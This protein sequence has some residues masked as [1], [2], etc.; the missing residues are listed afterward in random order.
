MDG[1]CSNWANS[2]VVF[3][4]CNNDRNQ[5]TTTSVIMGNACCS[6][7]ERPSKSNLI[8][9]PTSKS[10]KKHRYE[11]V[12][13]DYESEDDVWFDAL[14]YHEDEEQPGFEDEKQN[15]GEQSFPVTAQELITLKS[16][17][18]AKFP[19]DYGYMDD[20]YIRSVASKPYSKDLTRRRPIEYSLE[21]LVKVMDW[22]RRNQVSEMQDWVNL[23]VH[24]NHENRDSYDKGKSIVDTLN[25]GCFY[26]HGLDRAG[27][28]ILW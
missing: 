12:Y 9:V 26:W 5:D 7:E 28:P 19:Q 25:L 16:E 6:C 2:F 18:E 8:V 3:Y 22:R 15:T 11:E 14:Q 10:S 24:N 27:R 23:A 4:C 17:L 13:D 1:I 20:E 21:K